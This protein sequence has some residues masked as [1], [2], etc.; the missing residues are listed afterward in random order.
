MDKHFFYSHV[1]LENIKS[2]IKIVLR[3]DSTFS[4]AGL[5]VLGIESFID[6]YKQNFKNYISLN[7][8]PFLI[9]TGCGSLQQLENYLYD[10]DTIQYL[11]VTG[12]D[13]YLYE[14][15]YSSTGA[16][17]K[18]Y[19]EGPQLTKN[20][21]DYVQKNKTIIQ[22]F[23]TTKDSLE[24]LYSFELESIKTF[25][26]KNKLENVNVYCCDYNST[27]Y[28][29]SKYPMMS[30]ETKNL[31]LFNVFSRIK[32]QHTNHLKRSN[33][34]THK[35]IS[36][37]SNYKGFR[38]LTAAYLLDKTSILSFDKSK[39][40]LGEL[41]NY[42][43]FDL[44]SWKKHYSKIYLK[45]STNLERLDQSPLLRLESTNIALPNANF[46]NH[47]D[48][49]PEAV[50]SKCF[51]SVVTETKFSHPVSTFSEKTINAIHRFRPFILVAPPHT[52]EYLKTYGFKTFSDY[53]DES[54]D[55][56]ENHEKRLIK[57]FKTIDYIDQLPITSL[58]RLYDNMLP[59][60]EYNFKLLQT[61]P[62]TYYGN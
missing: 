59:I 40:V 42:L 39:A 24:T 6:Y 27:K 31:Y 48:Y 20:I 47:F 60:L 1:V 13:I 32:K 54:Y 8:S 38:H 21:K 23:E 30:I 49:A 51:C 53:W 15:L 25:I 44:E 52:L 11:N 16:K 28:F 50:Y 4:E 14:D 45:L 19:L 57:I 35:F 41:K 22:G 2:S 34:I 3:D 12:L 10:S 62:E 29:Q 37:N 56:E 7:K 26:E 58:K 43:W 55:Q 61:L 36:A 5:K 33:L 17:V 18:N 46:E 9:C